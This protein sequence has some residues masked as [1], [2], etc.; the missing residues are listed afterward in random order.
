[1]PAQEDYESLQQLAERLQLDEKESESFI[2]SSMQRMGY[3][4]KTQWDEPE[5]EG[6]GGDKG[7]DFFSGRR[8]QRQQ[9]EVTNGG[10]REQQRRTGSYGYE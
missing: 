8:Q 7:G 5:E 9:R 1:M 4:P 10:R 6:N 3:K 2:T